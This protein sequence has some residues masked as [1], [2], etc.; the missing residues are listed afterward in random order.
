[1]EIVQGRGTY[2]GGRV[3]SNAEADRVEMRLERSGGRP[4]L[5]QVGTDLGI[6]KKC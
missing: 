4:I 1:M 3:G 2:I 6:W 5:P